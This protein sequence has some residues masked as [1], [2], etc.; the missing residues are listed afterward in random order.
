MSHTARIPMTL[1]VTYK[2]DGQLTL[3]EIA[4]VISLS[5]GTSN[6]DELDVL[7]YHWEANYTVDQGSVRPPQG[8]KA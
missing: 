5:V 4:N 8:V 7:Y 6:T 1:E 3:D 2:S